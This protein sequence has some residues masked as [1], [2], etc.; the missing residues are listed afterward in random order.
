ARLRPENLVVLLRL[1]S[2]ALAAGGAGDR[3][4]ATAAYLRVREIA[5]GEATAEGPLREVL[6]ALERD[7]LAAA[8][9]PAIRLE[10]VLKVTPMYQGSQREL[11]RNIQGVPP[12]RFGAPVKVELKA[13]LLYPTPSAGAGLAV[14]DLDGNRRPDIVR[15]VGGDRPGIEVRLAA[16][17]WKALPVVAAP[18]ASQ[19]LAVDLDNDSRTDVI[20]WGERGGQVFL[21]NGQGG[22]RPA[23]ESFRIAGGGAAGNA[24]AAAVLDYDGDGDLDLA[25]AGSSGAGLELYRNNLAG[26]QAVGASALPRP[27]AGVGLAG[28]IRQLLASCLH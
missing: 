19:L 1:G 24:S 27:S 18:G 10:N 13:S 7:D 26:L 4:A 21:G 6:D 9:V 14:A 2:S 22:L 3:A 20:A 16:S 28:S 8:R 12:S 25:V 15:L 11:A 5:G 17:G 23:P